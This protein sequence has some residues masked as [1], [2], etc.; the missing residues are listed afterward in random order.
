MREVSALVAVDV[1][2]RVGLDSGASEPACACP[3]WRIDPGEKPFGS[4]QV[5][6]V[7]LTSAQDVPLL[8]D[9]ASVSAVHLS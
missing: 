4:G 3:Y 8:V 5:S 6:V 7:G 1:D 9:L 2:V